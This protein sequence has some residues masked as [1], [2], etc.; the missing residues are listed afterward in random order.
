MDRKAV[1]A[2]DGNI[3]NS[4]NRSRNPSFQERQ[5]K[6]Q[7]EREHL[8]NPEAYQESISSS[9]SRDIE[10]DA[11][12]VFFHG[13]PNRREQN[14]RKN[15]GEGKVTSQPSD[16]PGRWLQSRGSEVQSRP[17]ERKSY[18]SKLG[19]LKGGEGEPDKKEETTK[20]ETTEQVVVIVAEKITFHPSEAEK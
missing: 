6:R 7:A 4:G 14:W 15:R 20:E 19:Q 11:G 9:S 13:K 2:L 8:H 1:K 12:P 18:T 17:H 10:Q 16:N 5:F 3:Q